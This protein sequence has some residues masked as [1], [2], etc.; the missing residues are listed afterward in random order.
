M[1]SFPKT[2]S[3]A[4]FHAT[5]EF[6]RNIENALD[7]S[8]LTTLLAA[9]FKSLFSL[10]GI[11][12]NLVDESFDFVPAYQSPEEEGEFFGKVKSFLVDSG[13]FA[14]T[15]DSGKTVPFEIPRDLIQARMV[16]T[17]IL[18]PLFVK[19]RVLGMLELY[20]YMEPGRIPIEILDS[21]SKTIRFVSRHY[22]LLKL[23]DENTDLLKRM[24]VMQSYRENIISH[25]TDALVVTDSDFYIHEINRAGL[26]LL[27]LTRG[28]VLGRNLKL[29]FASESGNLFERLIPRI[30]K[31]GEVRNV[32]LELEDRLGTGIPVNFS[33]AL[34]QNKKGQNEGVV[35]ILRDITE[36]KGLIQGLEAAKIEI[37]DHNLS[38]EEKIRERT[39]ELSDKMDEIKY[40]SEYNAG[41]LENMPSGILGLDSAMKVNI[42]N[43]AASFITGVE[44]FDILGKNLM[45]FPL[46][47]NL[48]ELAERSVNEKNA[49][50]GQ[51]VI[52]IHSDGREVSL[53]VSTSILHNK[54][55][56]LSG[57]MLV[58]ADVTIIR[59][60]HQ[61]ILDSERMAALGKMAASVAHEIRNPLN[62]VR[63][64]AEI[65]S[66]KKV[67][68]E[69]TNKYMS[70]IIGQIDRL[71]FLLKEIVDFIKPRPPSLIKQNIEDIV[72][73]VLETFKEGFL[74]FSKKEIEI[75]LVTTPSISPV[76][77][78]RDQ[79]QQILYNLLKNSVDAIQLKGII[80][81]K[82]SEEAE[83]VIL[84]V[85][86]DGCGMDEYVC[87]H[88]Y[89]AFFTTK[90]TKGTGLGLS[91]VKNIMDAHKALIEIR[92]A[93]MQGTA[94]ILKFPKEVVP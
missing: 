63:G 71:E 21:I 25:I 43:K 88:A 60:M 76:A 50:N 4:E 16:K 51:E 68:R 36:L 42:F 74:Y 49:M 57:V 79:F 29:L 64:L 86:D 17:C 12:L 33:A 87:K 75:R 23:K 1:N 35:A 70:V 65:I 54:L 62:V 84:S 90:A 18:S 27:G 9:R 2:E 20:T 52:I 15:L 32:E 19:E 45:D 26:R 22:L 61:K 83:H 40:L 41:I 93:P 78:D 66:R 48:F 72:Q 38:L 67:D 92:S 47:K 69:K 5:E 77:V 91:I 94:F 8:M 55:R 56:E 85:E 59:V 30:F 81:L 14:G 34:F 80:T 89:D 10:F 11:V 28:D 73:E 13:G 39:T 58:F 7:V 6:Q 82:T 37:E 46:L 44:T 31:E 3:P 53:S 24:E